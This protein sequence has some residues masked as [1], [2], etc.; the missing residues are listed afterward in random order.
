LAA[1]LFLSLLYWRAPAAID[2]A[3][4]LIGSL[5]GTTNPLIFTIAAEA[6]ELGPVVMGGAIGIVTSVS[7]VAGFLVPTI[8]GKFLGSLSTATEHSFQIVLILAACY[9]LGIFIC[10]ALMRETGRMRGTRAIIGNSAASA[11]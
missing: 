9:V 8:T 10:A 3:A 7:S 6:D 11:Q 5:F 1:L 2:V 4:F